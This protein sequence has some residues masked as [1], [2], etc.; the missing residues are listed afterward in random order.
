MIPTFFA[1]LTLVL[2]P[3][4][5][6]DLTTLVRSTLERCVSGQDTIVG[7]TVDV[8]DADWARPFRNDQA[9]G[10]MAEGWTGDDGALVAAA[11][12]AVGAE[13]PDWTGVVRESR[14]NESGRAL[15]TQLEQ[16]EGWAPASLR[17]IEPPAG[18]TGPV[19]IHFSRAG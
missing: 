2:A 19:E 12:A 10:L 16:A 13:G 11:R 15:W 14:V 17:I 3:Q 18:Q 5:A 1:A 7:G 8:A 9:C 4:Q 6:P